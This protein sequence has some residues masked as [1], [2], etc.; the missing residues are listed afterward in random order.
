MKARIFSYYCILS[1]FCFGNNDAICINTR[2]PHSRFFLNICKYY[3]IMTKKNISIV[4]RFPW[5]DEI[6]AGLWLKIRTLWLLS[7]LRAT[8]FSAIS[9][10]FHWAPR[11]INLNSMLSNSY[12]QWSPQEWIRSYFWYLCS[13]IAW[14][15]KKRNQCFELL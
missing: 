13:K 9:F 1:Q 8:L 14:F 10:L 5:I 15:F 2:V 4:S 12:L 11:A 7:S 3:S 6:N